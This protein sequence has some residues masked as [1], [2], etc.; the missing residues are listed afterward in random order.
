GQI[1]PYAGEAAHVGLAAELAFAADFARHARDFRGERSKLIDHRVDGIFELEDFPFNI[2]GDL[3][4][5]V[6]I[7]DGGGYG[8]DIAHLAGEVSCHRLVR[9]GQVFPR[10][11]DAVDFG[12]AAELSFGAD[13]AC[14]ARHFGGERRKLIDHRVDGVFELKDFTFNVHGDFLGEIAVSHGG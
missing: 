12:L 10:A 13:L 1:L 5:E 3:L 2:D 11:G 7:G 8:S 9:S 6:A 4:R 14:H